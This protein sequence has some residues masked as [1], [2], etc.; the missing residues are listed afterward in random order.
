MIF[1]LPLSCP[2]QVSESNP[3]NGAMSDKTRNN[4]KQCLAH[5]CFSECIDVIKLILFFCIDS[6]ERS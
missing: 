6:V 3:G 2:L 5:D 1:L 4:Y